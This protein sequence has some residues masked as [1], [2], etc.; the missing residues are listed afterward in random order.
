MPCCARIKSLDVGQNDIGY[1]SK[2]IG[3]LI[4]MCLHD[5]DMICMLLA[6]AGLHLV[7]VICT[8][9]AQFKSHLDQKILP[10]LKAP[11]KSPSATAEPE[12]VAE[13]LGE[14]LFLPTCLLSPPSSSPLRP[15]VL[16]L[17]DLLLLLLLLTFLGLV[18]WPAPLA[19]LLLL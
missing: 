10:F 1:Y 5:I 9:N 18:L 16:L 12:G 17:L 11:G 14:A 3:N 6:E 7:P 13:V 2:L 4:L 8:D 19:W 15:P